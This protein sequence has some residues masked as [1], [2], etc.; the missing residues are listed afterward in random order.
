V[1][2]RFATLIALWG[3]GLASLPSSAS[4]Q[5]NG[6]WFF[7]Y[8]DPPTFGRGSYVYTRVSYIGE[9]AIPQGEIASAMAQANPQVSGRQ[10]S[11]WRYGSREEAEDRRRQGMILD[12][13]RNYTIQEISWASPYSPPVTPPETE[14][15]V[16]PDSASATPS[17]PSTTPQSAQAVT[18]RTASEERFAR[19]LAEYE[20]KMAEHARQQAEY[21]R[22]L[23]AE[24]QQRE[25]AAARAD[26][27]RKRY[28]QKRTRWQADVEAC[29]AGDHSRCASTP[30]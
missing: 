30:E 6:P 19:E 25:Q 1:R 11:C 2:L 20:R 27:A 9:A 15:A 18:S 12:R 13:R 4:A 5:S 28:E 14:A 17:T 23:Q 29:K 26:E 3:A 8:V 7:C 24:E 21:A 22:A 10:L 16:A